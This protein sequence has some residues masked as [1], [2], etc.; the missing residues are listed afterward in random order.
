MDKSTKIKCFWCGVF[1]VVTI[2]AES[3]PIICYKCHHATMPHLPENNHTAQYSHMP[4][5]AV[6]GISDTAMVS[7]YKQS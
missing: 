1:L 3:L 6:F 4:I 5:A 2:G 7:I